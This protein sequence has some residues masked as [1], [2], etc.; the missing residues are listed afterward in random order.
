M[1]EAQFEVELY[2]RVREYAESVNMGPGV[3]LV[4]LASAAARIIAFTVDVP[5]LS[6]Q[7]KV[8]VVNHNVKAV[9][10]ATRIG[11]MVAVGLLTKEGA[12]AEVL[13]MHEEMQPA[14]SALQAMARERDPNRFV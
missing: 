10:E 5:S 3:T 8:D 1:N 7:E 13:Q 2:R 14:A 6:E 12:E 9:A 4:A 11:A